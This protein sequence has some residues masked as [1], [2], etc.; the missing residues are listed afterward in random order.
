MGRDTGDQCREAWGL[1]VKG[2]ASL[3]LF[4]LCF[5]DLPVLLGGDFDLDV[6]RLRERDLHRSQERRCD[7]NR[8]QEQPGAFECRATGS[9]ASRSL[10]AFGIINFQSSQADKL[11]QGARHQRQIE[12]GSDTDMRQR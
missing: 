8:D 4:F 3:G 2:E 6:E 7:L 11:C 1:E 12:W 10:M 9:F 5:L